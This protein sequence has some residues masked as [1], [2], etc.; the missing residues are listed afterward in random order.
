MKKTSKTLFFILSLSFLTFSAFGKTINFKA[1]SMEGNVGEKNT[2]SVLTG[3]AWV[4]TEEIELS[5][6]NINISGEDYEN[7]TASG[8]VKG[9]Y[10]ESGM[11]FTC[12]QLEYNQ[13]TGIVFLKENVTLEDTENEVSAKAKLVEYNQNTDVA[14]LQINVDL[15]QKNS[16]CT[17]TF[18]IYNKKNKTLILT[19]K[20]KI[21]RDKDVFTAQEIMLNL[22]TEEI[23]LDG[24]VQGTVENKDEKPE[25]ESEKETAP[26]TE[27]K[28][29]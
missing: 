28:K 12:D 6:D 1:D 9:K 4:Q 26:K 29:K 16:H 3:N 15:T 17:A 14:V 27:G 24:Q 21:E 18:G 19:G 20:P 22:D 8:N 7:I 2:Y 5:A 25:S 23:T 13:D 11:T 10:I